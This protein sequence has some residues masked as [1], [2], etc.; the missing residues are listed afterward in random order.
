[1]IPKTEIK[2]SDPSDYRPIS[3]TSCVGKLAE[4]VVK[5]RL[6]NF[7]EKNN[8]IPIQQSGF[9]NK[10]GTTDNLLFITQKI[11]EAINRGRR[12]CG[13]FFDISKAF[14][15]VWHAGVIYKLIL[16]K[17]PNYLSRFI[18]NFLS[19]RKGKVTLNDVL[20]F[21]IGMCCG[22]PQGSVLG[23]LLFLVFF[24]IPL[25]NS[26]HLSYSALFADDLVSLF[27]FGKKESTKVLNRIKKYLQSLVEWLFKWRL[28]MNTSKCCYT[29]FSSSGRAGI[30][31]DLKL[32]SEPIPYKS[33][34]IFLGITFDEHLNFSAHYANLRARALK[35]LNIIKIFSHKSWHINQKTLTSV[36]RAIIGS[37]FD[38]SFFTIAD[39]SDKNLEL[40][41]TVQNRAIRCI[42]R[43]PWKSP[44][45]EL[46]L[47]SG[48]LPLKQRF[49]QLGGRYL[50]KAI[51]FKNRFI[52]TLVSEYIGSMS[53][54]TH[55]NKNK[56][57]K[58]K[59]KLYTPLCIF[60]TVIAL[61]AFTLI[62][63][64]INIF[65]LRFYIYYLLYLFNLP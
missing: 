14:D 30:C 55:K 16:F 4:R 26:K 44:R 52:S 12:A 50:A 7:L 37:I 53:S 27:L 23:P 43:L 35:R 22:I 57:K 56:T 36:Y 48:V 49:F 32:K 20:S 9:R 34:P 33:N 64:A 24:E 2:S 1:M 65:K 31:L 3:L 19:N 29:I 54:I 61:S 25:A 38:Y 10:R 11:K 13:I 6:Y 60:C 5:K 15:R 41:Q 17:V 45:N 21:I 63:I 18:R 42:Y 51:Y 39:C 59:N 62:T 47:I 40:L 28:K 8:L 46:F 58:N